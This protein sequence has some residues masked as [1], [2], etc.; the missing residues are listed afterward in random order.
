MNFLL[1]LC[2]LITDVYNDTSDECRFANRRCWIFFGC[3]AGVAITCCNL[4]RR[5]ETRKQPR[6][7]KES[8]VCHDG[9]SLQQ[10][11]CVVV[12][13][14]PLPNQRIRSPNRTHHFFRNEDT[15]TTSPKTKF[16]TALSILF[17]TSRTLRTTIGDSINSNNNDN[18]NQ[19]EETERWSLVVFVV[20]LVGG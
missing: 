1:R 20:I 6:E 17:I 8:G 12:G 14:V 5:S 7:K 9:S 10:K 16:T 11:C 13:F 4:G 2:C 18:N 19:T 3:V 15:T